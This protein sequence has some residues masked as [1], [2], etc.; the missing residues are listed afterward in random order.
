MKPILT[1]FFKK[2]M[3]GKGENGNSFILY[4]MLMP[5]MF[6]FF[7]LAIDVGVAN[8]TATSLQS[9]MDE[10]V[11]AAVSSADSSI[12]AN[13]LNGFVL[14]SDQAK[15]V[16]IKVYDANRADS[17]GNPSKSVPFLACQGKDHPYATSGTPITPP[18]GCG[19]T[20]KSFTFTPGILPSVRA[21]VTEYSHYI[22]LPMIGIPYQEYN[23]SGF[24]Y[25]EAH[26]R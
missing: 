7:G 23:I 21:T 22:F 1:N 13:G 8:Y 17:N 11:Q 24:G 3:Q 18:S 9:D 20:L 14:S 12:N 5:V 19:F 2:R 10:G 6:A 16:L 26:L 15:S 25:V 4:F